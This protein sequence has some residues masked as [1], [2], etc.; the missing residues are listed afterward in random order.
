MKNP[1]NP[2]INM[3]NYEKIPFLIL[4]EPTNLE[5]FNKDMENWYLEQIYQIELELKGQLNSEYEN[6]LKNKHDYLLM[7]LYSGN[8]FL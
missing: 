1:N 7:A 6:Y 5:K 4:N 8:L 2:Y 3:D